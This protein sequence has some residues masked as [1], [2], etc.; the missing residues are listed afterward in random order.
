MTVRPFYVCSRVSPDHDRCISLGSSELCF[1][2]LLSFAYRAGGT[3]TPAS[4]YE[5]QTDDGHRLIDHRIVTLDVGSEPLRTFAVHESILREH[6]PFFR[7]A[8]DQ[9]WRE[10]RSRVV[11]LPMDDEDVVA[12]YVDFL[13]FGKVASRPVSPP[14]LP[15]DDGEF[16]FLSRC[17]IFADKVGA[18]IFCD[19]IIDAM[20]LKTD[21]VAG[22]GTRTF[23]SYTAIMTLYNGTP[24]DSPARRFAVD[25]Y[26]E[27][28]IESWI[29]KEADLSHAEFLTDLARRFLSRKQ[30]VTTHKQ[31]NYPKRTRWHKGDSSREF[32]RPAASIETFGPREAE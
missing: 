30:S 2:R 20:A 28:G 11:E 19:A 27:F 6:S 4:T 25:M 23:P 17:Y 21:D 24:P 13:Y 31:P 5:A 14:E 22:D 32:L 7:A 16:S 8:L 29:P 18:D 3:H 26:V 1:M 15:V 10:G 12:A 9:K